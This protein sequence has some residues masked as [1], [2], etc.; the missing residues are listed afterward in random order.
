MSESYQVRNVPHYFLSAQLL[1][2]SPPMFSP[3]LGGLEAWMH[4]VVSPLSELSVT[5]VL[6]F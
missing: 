5:F 6:V 3:F 2:L 1:S 4:K